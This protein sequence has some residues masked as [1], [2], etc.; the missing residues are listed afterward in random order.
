MV[1]IYGRV[2][3]SGSAPH[4]R[5]WSMAESLRVIVGRC[6]AQVLGNS[7]SPRA[8]ATKSSDRSPRHEDVDGSIT[9]SL[10][11]QLGA[12]PTE[13]EGQRCQSTQAIR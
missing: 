12:Q 2:G 4:S 1:D 7:Y 13:D 5:E 10:T 3:V 11:Y 8:T 9:I 6:I